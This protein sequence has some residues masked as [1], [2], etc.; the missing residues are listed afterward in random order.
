[1]GVLMSFVGMATLLAIGFLLS[2]NKKRINVRTVGLALAIQFF[3]GGFVLYV[4]VGNTLLQAIS[5]GYSQLLTYVNEGT[6]FLFGYWLTDPSKDVGFVFALKVLP[7]TIYL[8]AL[9]SVLYY[10]GVMKVVIRIIGGGLRYV[11]G[12]SHTESLS[13]AAN[14]F[15][16]QTEA[17]LTVKPYIARMTESELFAVMVGGLASVAGSVLAGYI[18]M[19][20]P[21]PYLIAA[22][23]MAAPGGLLFAKLIVPE[24]DTPE[25]IN[26]N[27][28]D[29]DA[30]VNVLEAA[31]RGASDGLF[32]VLNIAA[33]LLAFLSILAL[34]NAVIS[35]FFSLFGVDGVTLQ[36]LLGY[37]LRY[38]AFLM[39]VPWQDADFAGS[40]IGIKFVTNEFVGYLEL[41][42]KIA[43]DANGLY[44]G[45]NGIEPVT[46]V[47][48]SFALCGFANLGSI[49]IIIGGIGV[50]AP[51]R[52]GDIARLGLRAV[53][54]GTLSNLM[55][56]TIAG[57]F[58]NLSGGFSF[59]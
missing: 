30:P 33:M 38:L 37:V 4:P 53:L 19:G 36:V 24:V 1:M 17:P 16:G 25:V 35:W 29:E 6:N 3:F 22:S 14:I 21:A 59:A 49:A 27:A 34:L 58:Y 23:F 12:T 42:N 57:F 43:R 46:G 11:L 44:A 47:I 18:G 28:K 20:V 15:V 39:G 31:A 32:L 45:W 5:N 10:L 8:A 50:M 54:G 52:R 2:N 56:A 7:V 41:A 48:M 40:L 55:S 13:A 9:I 51:S 26:D